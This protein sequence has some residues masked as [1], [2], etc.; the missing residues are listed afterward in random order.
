MKRLLFGI[1]RWIINT[2][3]FDQM[4]E[5]YQR[6]ALNYVFLIFYTTLEGVFVNTL[7]YKISPS[8]TGVIIY[9]AITYVAAAITMHLA[10]YISQKKSPLVVI[11]M[12]GMFFLLMYV[13]LFAGFNHMDKLSYVV[14]VLSG[15]GGAFYWTAHNIFVADYTTKHNRDLGISL[16]GV[17][18][19]II[20]L[21]CPVISGFVI[22][23]LPGDLG[24]RI[25]FGIGMA[26]V[27]AQIW[28]QLKLHPVPQKQHTSQIRLAFRLL[29]EKLSYKLMMGYEFIRGI[30]DGTFAFILN[31]LLFEIITDEALVGINTFLTGIMAIIGSWVYGRL[32]RSRTRA[33]YTVIST[34]VLLG[35]CASLFLK[36]SAPTVMIY[37]A[38]NA[39]LQLFILNSYNN[40]TFDVLGEDEL[41]RK[42]MGEML[43]IR[44]AALAGG[45]ILGLSV[46]MAFPDTP[47]GYVQ[48][49]CVLT[50]VQYIAAIVM[51]KAQNYLARK[52]QYEQ[53]T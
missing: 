16:L 44:E 25:M 11:R 33:R 30:R 50:A 17:I 18:Q 32:V 19:G 28:V 36:M 7:L 4:G 34:T 52:E 24:Y 26:A 14:A 6:L 53:A 31:M 9:R 8:M 10:A 45:R 5:K 51:K 1:R 23:R 13:V 22:G 48:A 37:T 42:S 2:L 40:T 27:G 38:V 47:T 29:R 49:M 15:T 20:T 39:F 35:V 41:T 12:G 3:G 43:A 46:M 21:I